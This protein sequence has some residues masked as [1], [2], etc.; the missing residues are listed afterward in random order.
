MA[1]D[2]GRQAF[3]GGKFV[4]VEPAQS[5]ASRQRFGEDVGQITVLFYEA[6]PP[7]RSRDPFGFTRSVGTG[8]DAA[9]KRYE[10]QVPNKD[11]K[12]GNMLAP[13]TIYYVDTDAFTSEP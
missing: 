13:V 10:Y 6:L 5:L 8:E 12:F 9:K 4:V 7:A 3:E 2:P 11:L 1:G